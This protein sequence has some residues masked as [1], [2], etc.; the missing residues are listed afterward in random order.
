MFKTCMLYVKCTF[1]Y[2]DKQSEALQNGSSGGTTFRHIG[3]LTCK[4]QWIEWQRGGPIIPLRKSGS[5]V[6]WSPRA[7]LWCGSRDEK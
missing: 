3:L 4:T 6:W 7:T 5:G 1:H 2:P